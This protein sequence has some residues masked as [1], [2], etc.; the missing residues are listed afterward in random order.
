MKTF[1]DNGYN[2]RWVNWAA[3]IE[4]YKA[5][6]ERV[7]SLEDIEPLSSQLGRGCNGSDPS[8]YPTE[9]QTA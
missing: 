2:D 7:Y 5:T 6:R 9:R 8:F 1:T 3:F 4:N